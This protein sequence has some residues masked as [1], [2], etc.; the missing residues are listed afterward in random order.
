MPC[1]SFHSF[2]FF[3]NDTATTEI[4]T[5]S[6]HDALPIYRGIEREAV[7]ALPRRVH[8]HRT[9]AVQ[10]VAGGDLR[11]ALLETV[12]ERARASLGGAAPMN[13]EDRADRD[14]DADVGRAVERIVQQHVLAA[15][16]ILTHLDRD[17]LF[18]LLRRDDA[19]PARV[20][21][22]VPHRLVGE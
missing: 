21:D 17:G 1:P 10:D 11:A 12:G 7:H 13:G 15:A 2:F 5:L 6:L 9:G 4:Y 3:F 18:V 19:D 8:E 22:A 20:L 14:V 16:P